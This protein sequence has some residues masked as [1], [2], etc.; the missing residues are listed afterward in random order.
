MGGRLKRGRIY[1]CIWLIHD[2]QQKLIQ[3]DKALIYNNNN[4]NKILTRNPQASTACKG[5]F[6]IKKVKNLALNAFV[7]P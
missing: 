3:H 6:G 7:R 5:S 4:N 1:A 2:V